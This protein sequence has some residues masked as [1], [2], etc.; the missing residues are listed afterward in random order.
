MVRLI[1]AFVLCPVYFVTLYIYVMDFLAAAVSWYRFV[2]FC[3]LERKE[4]CRSCR[5][6]EIA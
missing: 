2:L 1:F 6:K 5:Y 3:T 4:K